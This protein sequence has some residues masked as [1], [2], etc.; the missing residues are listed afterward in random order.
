[1][2]GER[3]KVLKRTPSTSEISAALSR[4]EPPQSRELKDGDPQVA[5]VY[6]YMSQFTDLTPDDC[7]VDLGSGSGLLSTVLDDIWPSDRKPPRYVAVDL[8]EPLSK[9]SLPFRV[10]NNSEKVLFDDFF[11]LRANELSSAIKLV[12]IR[13][14][15]HELDICTT[16]RVLSG[17]NSALPPGTPIYIQDMSILPNPERGNAGWDSELFQ[18]FLTT[19]GFSPVVPTLTSHSGIDWFFTTITTIPREIP[20]SEAATACAAERHKQK[21][22]LHERLLASKEDYSDDSATARWV[23]LSLQVSAL[24]LQLGQHAQESASSS[25]SAEPT[26]SKQRI[27]LRKG[28]LAGDGEGP[29]NPVGFL[30]GVR[31]K[32]EIDIASMIAASKKIVRFAG[33]SQK[34]TFALPDNLSA[35]EA[36]AERGVSLQFLIS[37]PA[38]AA[39]LV[40]AN[41]QLYSTSTE[42]ITDIEDS[43][44][45]YARFIAHLRAG[46]KDHIGSR[47]EM[48]LT[49]SIYPCSY[50][51]IDDL[52]F[53]SLYMQRLSGSLGPCL[54]FEDEG[55]SEV[56]Y[57]HLL[58]QEFAV[59]FASAQVAS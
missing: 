19:I 58:L 18:S 16:A 37:D 49:D 15:F 23:D 35:I 34:Y 31:N 40:R 24:D 22:A 8:L 51:V 20:A 33:Y 54:V 48:R 26:P 30:S 10:H 13:N 27:L 17:L 45:H 25:P 47:I 32:E 11:G 6:Q 50:F 46:G 57:Y 3:C 21:L 5:A 36:A 55:G 4:P 12:I 52:C 39:T 53:V 56:G 14:V 43:I 28:A 38:A 2:G 9:L 29:I 42:L 59:V 41:A 44:G 7:I 1:M